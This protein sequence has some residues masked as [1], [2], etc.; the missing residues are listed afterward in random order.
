VL[1]FHAAGCCFEKFRKRRFLKR[2]LTH[3][4]TDR[5]RGDGKY[6]KAINADACELLIRLSGEMHAIMLNA[7]ETA[8]TTYKQKAITPEIIKE[9]F[10]TRSAGLYDKKADEH[11]NIIS[12]Y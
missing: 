1:C 9:I 8:V 5:E 6:K 4:L 11:Y 3:A 12:R 2:L 7:L 10:Q